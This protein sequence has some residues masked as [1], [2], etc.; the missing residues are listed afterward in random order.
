M[1]AGPPGTAQPLLRSLSGFSRVAR[2]TRIRNFSLSTQSDRESLIAE[3]LD[4]N[5]YRKEQYEQELL[6]EKDMP[7]VELPHHV[8][9]L[10]RD[11]VATRT[12][13]IRQQLYYSNHQKFDYHDN[14]QVK[15]GWM[16]EDLLNAR[17]EF[18]KEMFAKP[19]YDTGIPD[20]SMDKLVELQDRYDT[21]EDLKINDDDTPDEKKTKALAQLQRYI[22]QTSQAIA[23]FPDASE[24]LKELKAVQRKMVTVD[25]EE[26]ELFLMENEGRIK[27]EE[28]EYKNLDEFMKANTHRMMDVM[29]A[30]MKD[31]LHSQIKHKPLDVLGLIKKGAIDAIDDQLKLLTKMQKKRLEEYT[32]RFGAMPNDEELQAQFTAETER[33]L[34]YEAELTQQ[35]QAIQEQE[36]LLDKESE[37]AAEEKQEE[38]ELSAE[39]QQQADARR[40]EN[41]KQQEAWAGLAKM[42]ASDFEDAVAGGARKGESPFEY[43]ARIGNEEWRAY[44]E[45][46]EKGESTE[47]FA[48]LLGN[49]RAL[50]SDISELEEDEKHLWGPVSDDEDEPF[51]ASSEE[52]EN[53]SES[54]SESSADDVPEIPTGP[55][56][57][58][59]APPKVDLSK[60]KH[61]KD[62]PYDR[63]EDPPTEFEIYIMDEFARQQQREE[64]KEKGITLFPR[65]PVPR[66]PQEESWVKKAL[67]LFRIRAIRVYIDN[68]KKSKKQQDQ[69]EYRDLDLLDHE[70]V[71]PENPWKL[72]L[73]EEC[74]LR[75]S[76][77]GLWTTAQKEEFLRILHHALT[78]PTKER[79]KRYT[80]SEADSTFTT[81]L[82]GDDNSKS[83]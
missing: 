2:C 37:A 57:E 53:N 17:R 70:I 15:K 14:I 60:Y 35:D 19:R 21:P 11:D 42:N 75:L 44:E 41:L 68:L 67:L 31:P 3:A 48:G 6:L 25:A 82:M 64:A 28:T 63:F 71:D 18:V 32:L 36:E 65:I 66:G 39:E 78:A 62:L 22:D 56:S 40:E 72:E 8:K 45:A 50:M 58:G 1:S 30:Q 47:R 79:L 27:E 16:S 49:P 12:W 23:E 20:V 81:K 26:I 43:A 13:K 51:R 69:R 77:T 80:L 46:L 33:Q 9:I 74:K 61:L 38:A 34:A 73:Y 5:S 24:H 4:R 7:D 76:N 54:S 10:P 29:E 59:P 83:K 52:G 55:S